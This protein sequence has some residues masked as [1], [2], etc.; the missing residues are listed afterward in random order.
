MV[1][2]NYTSVNEEIFNAVSHGIGALAG[3]VGFVVLMLHVQRAGQPDRFWGFF[4]FG[5]TLIFLYLISTLFHSLMFTRASKVLELLDYSAIALFIAGS[6]TPIA[7]ITLK[8]NF[9]LYLLIGV[10]V[11]A[12]VSILWRIFGIQKDKVALILYLFTGWLIVVFIK[13]LTQQLPHS[14]LLL[15]I[16]GGVSYTVGTIFFQWR[17]LTF[18][19]GIWHIFVLVGS[20]C[21]F[22]TMLYI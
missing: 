15:L 18:N 14:A 17:K 4:I 22:L 21:H 8:S 3:I 13:P 12:I 10:W 1:R 20:V 16:I 9:G 5:T 11:L 2:I 6:Y 7:L 19:H